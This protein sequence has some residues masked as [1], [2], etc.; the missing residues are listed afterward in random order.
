[1]IK[2]KEQV[3]KE[4]RSRLKSLSY[5]PIICLSALKGKGINLLVKSLGEMINQSQ[6]KLTKK[7][8]GEIIEKMLV[9]NPPKHHQ[10]GK[11]KIY[12]AKQEPGLVHYFIF[13]VNNP[14]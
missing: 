11:L 6:K 3:V 14:R 8:I 2:T 4:L 13:F 7:E 1:L 9:N 5:C 10:G 12:F